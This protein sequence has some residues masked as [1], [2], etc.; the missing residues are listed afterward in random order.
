MRNENFYFSS[1]FD[2]DDIKFSFEKIEIYIQS[3]TIYVDINSFS[4]DN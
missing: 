2:L 3:F 4:L 1:V